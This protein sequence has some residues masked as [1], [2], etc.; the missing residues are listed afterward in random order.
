M[1]WWWY[2]GSGGSCGSGIDIISCIVAQMVFACGGI[3]LV[4]VVEIFALG[5]LAISK[6]FCVVFAQHQSPYQI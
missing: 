2:C 4:I 3:V 5:A 6:S 1:R